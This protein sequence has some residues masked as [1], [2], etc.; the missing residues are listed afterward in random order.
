[1][2]KLLFI[3]PLILLF[4]SC[5]TREDINKNKNKSPEVYLSLDKAGAYEL[6]IVDT[7]KMSESA[8]YYFKSSDDSDLALLHSVQKE[9]IDSKLDFKDSVS[10]TINEPAGEL[11]VSNTL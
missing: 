6:E 10:V 9:F 3:I 11:L 1:M 7:L 4:A 5:E 8:V 2:R